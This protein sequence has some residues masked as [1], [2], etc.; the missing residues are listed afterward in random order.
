MHACCQPCINPGKSIKLYEGILPNI[1]YITWQK[2]NLNQLT[3]YDYVYRAPWMKPNKSGMLNGVLT[4]K[5]Q[6][7]EKTQLT[8]INHPVKSP[9]MGIYESGFNGNYTSWYKSGFKA[10]SV[11]YINNLR[12][13]PSIEW[14]QNGEKYQEINYLKGCRHGKYQRG[15]EDGLLEI[16]AKCFEG[17][18]VSFN[19]GLASLF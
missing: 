10:L 17:Q 11:D 15:S 4:T 13:G 14:H 12:S 2:D 6:N 16:P 18:V 7:G 9:W 5:N 1:K 3:Y 19:N 8:F